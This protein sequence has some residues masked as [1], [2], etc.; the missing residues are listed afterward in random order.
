MPSTIAVIAPGSMGSA[1][2]KKLAENGARVLTFTEGRSE[3]T[4][5]RARAAGM[6]PAGLAEIAEADLIV[7]IVPP[8][9]RCRWR[10][11]S[12]LRSALAKR[13]PPS[14]T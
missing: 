4:V 10:R 7:S 6:M 1:V 5:A 13:S 2:G 12:R 11:R 14:S 3:Q 8:Q 9:R